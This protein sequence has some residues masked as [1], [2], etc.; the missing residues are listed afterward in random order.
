[1]KKPRMFQTSPSTDKSDNE[2]GGDVKVC[3]N[4]NNSFDNWK[5]FVS[6]NGNGHPVIGHQLSALLAQ[7]GHN[8]G[9]A[10]SLVVL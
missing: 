4:D 7:N 6:K 2:D 3:N 5:G 8:G 10:V 9:A 1:M